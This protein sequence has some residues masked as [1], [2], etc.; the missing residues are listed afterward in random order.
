MQGEQSNITKWIDALKIAIIENNIDNAMELIDNLPF[1]KDSIFNGKYDG[2]V[3][4]LEYLNIAKEL[5][6]QVLDILI[7]QQEDARN[8]IYKIKQARKFLTN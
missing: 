1:D 7:T 6:S 4:L 3:E 5:I 2:N 8:Q